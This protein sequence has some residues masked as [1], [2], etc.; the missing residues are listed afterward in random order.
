MNIVFFSFKTRVFLHVTNW[1]CSVCLWLHIVMSVSQECHYSST[2]IS[3]FF[4][5]FCNG[6]VKLSRGA[7]LLWFLVL[8]LLRMYARGLVFWRNFS[9]FADD[10]CDILSKF[11][12]KTIPPI[13]Q[14]IDKWMNDDNDK[15]IL[16]YFCNEIYSLWIYK[17]QL[18]P[19]NI[20]CAMLIDKAWWMLIQYNAVGLKQFSCH[21]VI[22]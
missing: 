5:S 17:P 7:W 8:R 21:S 10:G 3:G 6:Q 9:P 14:L 19:C 18:S 20:I 11:R 16:V 4:V 15:S 1:Q 22:A 13:W 12:C 2:G